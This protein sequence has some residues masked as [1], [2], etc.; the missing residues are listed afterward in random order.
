[1]GSIVAVDWN[2]WVVSRRN[3]LPTT[4]PFQVGIEQLGRFS[5]TAIALSKQT[6]YDLN[7]L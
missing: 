5:P 4:H 3:Q 6:E 7:L 2:V 1:M